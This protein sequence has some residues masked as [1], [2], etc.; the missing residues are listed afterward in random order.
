MI[1]RD[2]HLMCPPAIFRAMT[3]LAVDAF[4]ALAA[5]VLPRRAVAERDRPARPGRQRATGCSWRWSGCGAT[6][7]PRCSAS[8]SASARRPR[9]GR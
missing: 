5:E 3:G 2:H 6:R 7:P 8:S 9:A 1:L 4:A